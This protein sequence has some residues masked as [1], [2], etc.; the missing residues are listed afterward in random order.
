V[1]AS[2][3]I[4]SKLR[5]IHGCSGFGEEGGRWFRFLVNFRTSW[6]STTTE[7]YPREQRR[8]SFET[9][10]STCSPS[11]SIVTYPGPAREVIPTVLRGWGFTEEPSSAAA[12]ATYLYRA[13]VFVSLGICIEDVFYAG[14]G[15]GPGVDGNI[16]DLVFLEMRLFVSLFVRISI[17]SSSSSSSSPSSSS[18]S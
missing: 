18:S 5:R 13:S 2:C 7:K 6:M 4:S 1:L 8:C 3:C 10:A 12:A 11:S 16:D 9:S 14:W 17:Y 15:H